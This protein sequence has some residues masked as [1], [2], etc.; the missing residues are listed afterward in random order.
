MESG[1]FGFLAPVYVR[2]FLDSYA[3][4]LGADPD[5]LLA[6]FDSSHE[7]PNELLQVIH[8][9]YDLTP[10]R[11]GLGSIAGIVLIVLVVLGVWNP[12]ADE[13]RESSTAAS[14]ST[15][16]ASPSPRGFA[17]TGEPPADEGS[18][19]GS[20]GSEV[21]LGNS[22]SGTRDPKISFTRG[23]DSRLAAASGPC[24]VEVVADGRI[25]FR[26]MMQP[27]TIKRFRAKGNMELLLGLPRSAE[28]LV[29]GR[30]LR[31]P[32]VETPI[33]IALPTEAERYL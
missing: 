1:D 4:Y 33:R 30:R 21:A 25:V 8:P 6:E 5:P 23:I 11:I 32:K 24:W 10:H 27:G 16:S 14:N 15:T 13:P 2:G 28:L 19:T 12:G 20:A 9:T 29:N 7:T 26:G 31:L 22:D 17:G 18:A 3:R